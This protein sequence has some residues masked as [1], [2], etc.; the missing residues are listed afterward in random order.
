MRTIS[1]K[2]DR[3]KKPM[4]S[5]GATKINLS[6]QKG[7]DTPEKKSYDFCT[8]CFL[9]VKCSFMGLLI[10]DEESEESDVNG[11]DPVSIKEGQDASGL[12]TGPIKEADRREIL[13]LYVEEGMDPDMIAKKMNRLPRGIKRAINTAEKTGELA[14]LRA[15]AKTESEGALLSEIMGDGYQAAPKTEIIGGK[16]YDVGSIMALKKAGWKI[17]DIAAE[18][19]YDETVVAL[20]LEKYLLNT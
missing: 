2:C 7:A 14:D 17:S 6:V 8:S 20:L 4:T 1:Y 11:P 3:C 18:K 16:K 13:R 5:R 10:P 9:K 19:H 12:I 15:K